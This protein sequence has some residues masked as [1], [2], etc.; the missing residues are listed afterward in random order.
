MSECNERLIDSR[1]ERIENQKQ[2][3][4]EEINRC[5]NS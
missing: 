1:K 4:Q 5:K 2:N 3:F